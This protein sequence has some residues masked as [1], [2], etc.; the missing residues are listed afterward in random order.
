MAI[1]ANK[2]NIVRGTV[3][4]ANKRPLAGL[5]VQLHDVDMRNWQQ[6]AETGLLLILVKSDSRAFSPGLYGC[7]SI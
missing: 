4:D 2:Y 7:S 5:K 1:T 3:T 6:L